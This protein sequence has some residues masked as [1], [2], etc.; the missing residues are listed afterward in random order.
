MSHTIIVMTFEDE[1]GGVYKWCK[2]AKGHFYDY[3]RA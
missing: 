2:T 1:T 3:P